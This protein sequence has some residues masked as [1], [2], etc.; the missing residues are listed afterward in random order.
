MALFEEIEPPSLEKLA[1][2][3]T[4][5]TT[6]RKRNKNQ[7]LNIRLFLAK[8]SYAFRFTKQKAEELN[9]F[10]D[11]K[12]FLV[13]KNFLPHSV[14]M[15]LGI[16]VFMS[17]VND[18]LLSKAYGQSLI[19]TSPD[20]EYS[21]AEQADIYTPLIVGDANFVEKKVLAYERAGFLAS[22]GTVE[23]QITNRENIIVADASDNTINTIY[24]VVQNGDTLSGLGMKFDVKLAY[25]KYVNDLMD[26]N[27]I[28]PGSKLK[29]PPKNFSVSDSQIAKKDKE[30]KAKLATAQRDTVTRNG[31]LASTSSTPKVKVAPGSSKNGYPYG[32]CTYYVATRRAVPVNWGDAKRWLDSAKRAG[33]QT[34]GTPAVGSIVV[35]AESWWG[36]V[37]YVESVDGNNFTIAEMNAKGW[38]VT[39]RRTFSTSD[40]VVRGFI[41]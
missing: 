34:G 4:K 39:S 29:I 14:V 3:K 13:V 19:S 8:S 24:Y 30:L 10:N 36:H 40:R 17:N 20:L 2:E 21:I 1:I 32:Y 23:T 25:L 26:V 35:T 5:K 12:N 41:Y 16:L 9:P 33:Y 15:F 18:K 31:R 27:A 37:A 6:V 38:G 22:T 7:L 28:R 11:A